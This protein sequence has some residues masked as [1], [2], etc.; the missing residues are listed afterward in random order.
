MIDYDLNGT[1]ADEYANAVSLQNDK[2]QSYCIDRITNEQLRVAQAND[3]LLQ[4]VIKDCQHAQNATSSGA[5]FLRD[6]ILYKRSG[7]LQLL[8]VPREL[9]QA[10]L[11]SYHTHP[12]ASH[13]ARDRLFALLKTRFYWQGMFDHI[14]QFCKS[15]LICAKI[16]SRSPLRAGLLH[17]IPSNKPFQ[18]VG[19]DIVICRQSANSNRYILVIID[20]FT[21]WVEATPM[22]SL[23]SEELVR[24]FFHTVIARHGCPQQ[25]ISDSGTQFVSELFVNLCSTFNIQK[26][27]SSPYHQQANGKVEKFIQFLKQALALVTPIDKRH[28][29]DEMIDHCLIT[30]RV[31]VSRMLNDTPFHMLFGRDAIL[32][33]DLQFGLSEGNQR[34]VPEDDHHNYQWQLQHKLRAM[35]EEHVGKKQED[36]AKYKLYYDGSHHRVEF[37]IGDQVL[38]LFDIASKSFLEPKWEGPFTIIGRLD[39]VTYRLESLEKITTAHVQRIVLW[40]KGGENRKYKQVCKSEL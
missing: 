33:Q 22:K 12:L 25:L 20:Y 23:T 37:E 13:M 2:L 4:S 10:V 32:P 9:R 27:E 36:Q 16:K 39:D 17:P 24:A 19:A 34:A 6:G 26:T 31:T 8:V 40:K 15:C 21:N 28:R 38:V 30:Y 7:T 11:Q 5:F 3:P 1:A 35:Y 29:W 18:C 14:R